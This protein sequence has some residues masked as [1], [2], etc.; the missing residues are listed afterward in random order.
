MK[1]YG[2][3]DIIKKC[4]TLNHFLISHASCFIQ[5][6]CHQIAPI[7]ILADSIPT[8][9]IESEKPPPLFAGEVNRLS[10]NGHKLMIFYFNRLSTVLEFWFACASIAWDACVRTLFFVYAVISFAISAS[11]MV[12]SD[13]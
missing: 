9:K 12:D 4:K 13:A 7:T 5:I 1:D 10:G 2:H 3:K 6:S 11:R 8:C